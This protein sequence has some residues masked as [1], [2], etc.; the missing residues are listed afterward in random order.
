MDVLLQEMERWSTGNPLEKR[1]AAA[2]LCEPELLRNRNH[3]QTVLEI[4]D[5]ITA[6]I[7]GIEDRRSDGFKALRKG[8]GYCWSVVVVAVPGKGKRMMEKW[9]SSNDRD[10]VWIMKQN[11]SKKRLMRMDAEWV[12]RWKTELGV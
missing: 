8:L 11:L 10:I 4:L 9:F 12:E 3:T 7:E 2:G 5:R 1:A 6:S